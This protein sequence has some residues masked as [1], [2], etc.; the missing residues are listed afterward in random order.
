MQLH[1]LTLNQAHHMLKTKE[2]TS[3]ELTRA[4]LDRVTAL[5]P[6]VHAYISVAADE[7]LA[8]AEKADQ[9]IAQG[10]MDPLTGIPLGIKDVICT[11]DLRTTCGSRMLE[12]FVPPYDATVMQRLRAR[13]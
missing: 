7:A 9:A 2:I 4:V 6:Q 12:N 3:V 8:A 1:A 11:R 5:E 10:H 13:R